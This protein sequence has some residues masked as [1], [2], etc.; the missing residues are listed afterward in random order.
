MLLFF[1]SLFD[2]TRPLTEEK[3][4]HILLVPD[5]WFPLVLMRCHVYK[6]VVCFDGWGA[7][8]PNSFPQCDKCSLQMCPKNGQSIPASTIWYRELFQ[9]QL[10]LYMQY[11]VLCRGIC[12]YLEIFL[13]H[14]QRLCVKMWTICRLSAVFVSQKPDLDYIKFT[15]NKMTASEFEEHWK[16][17]KMTKKADF[18]HMIQVGDAGGA[19][20]PQ[21]GFDTNGSFSFGGAPQ[22]LIP[23][24]YVSN[25]VS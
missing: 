13:S 21:A 25:M 20:G 17:K 15:W 4:N 23:L 9:V 1:L 12:V 7:N 19:S 5:K 14:F 6:W 16:V 24:I 10:L 2:F 8:Y 3:N 22:K 11:N 18:I